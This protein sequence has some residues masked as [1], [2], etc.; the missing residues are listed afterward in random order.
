MAQVLMMGLMSLKEETLEGLFSLFQPY[1]D[2]VR[3]QLSL[4]Q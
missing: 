2:T 4:S 3:K 1:E